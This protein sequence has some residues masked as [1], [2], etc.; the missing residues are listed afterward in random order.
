MGANLFSLWPP[1]AK[2][3]LA[4][5][6]RQAGRQAGSLGEMLF[7][8]SAKELVLPPPRRPCSA[9]LSTPA[10]MRNGS[11]ITTTQMASHSAAKDGDV[12]QTV[13]STAPH[14]TTSKQRPKTAR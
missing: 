4:R 2:K 12:K 6:G 9:S 14:N 8:G 1:R 10:Q 7:D 3:T 11:R 5:G 13:K